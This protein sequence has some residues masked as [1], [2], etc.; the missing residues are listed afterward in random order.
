MCF[1]RVNRLYSVLKK[2][3]SSQYHDKFCDLFAALSL[4]KV[5]NIQ[6]LPL[7][8]LT[9][10]TYQRFL[11]VS[12]I[13][14]RRFVHCFGFLTMSS[15]LWRPKKLT[16][17]TGLYSKNLHS[18]LCSVAG[19]IYLLRSQPKDK[20]I[21]EQLGAWSFADTFRT[22]EKRNLSRFQAKIHWM[23]HFWDTSDALESPKS[24]LVFFQSVRFFTTRTKAHL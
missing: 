5:L 1:T 12:F 13:C 3:G 23:L 22:A 15:L 11:Q 20:A 19:I 7:H 14:H 8:M 9:D 10:P 16:F 2:Y 4:P 18:P 21:N 24:S 17:Y 6:N